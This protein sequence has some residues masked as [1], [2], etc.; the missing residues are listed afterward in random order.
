MERTLEHHVPCGAC[1]YVK[2]FDERFFRR[3]VIFRGETA[4]EEFL[5]SVM[6]IANE[7][8]NILKKENSCEATNPIINGGIYKC[9]KMSHL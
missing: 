7:L 2:S 4:V 9:R 3:P 5:D 6:W 1:F 8:R